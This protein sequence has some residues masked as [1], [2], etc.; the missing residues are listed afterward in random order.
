M[1]SNPFRRR[2]VLQLTPLAALAVLPAVGLLVAGSVPLPAR[3]LLASTAILAAPAAW[4]AYRGVIRH[5][6][7]AARTLGGHADQIT[8][9]AGLVSAANGGSAEGASRQ[10]ASIEEASSSLEEI[11]SMIQRNADHARQANELAEEACA[12]AD[13]GV[14][15]LHAIG[16]AID[17]LNGSSGEIANIIKTIDGIAFQTNLLALNAAVEAARAGSAGA[18]FAIV[19]DEVRK[20][21]GRTTAA[22]Q[23]SAAKIDEVVSWI[24]QCEILKVEVGGSLDNIAAKAR[25]VVELAA[26]VADASRQQA[27]GL[28]QVNTSVVEVSRVTQQSVADTEACA[29]A[30]V[31]LEAH[32]RSLA[33]ALQ[34]L[35]GLGGDGTGPTADPGPAA[36]TGT[37]EA[38]TPPDCLP[39]HRAT[40]PVPVRS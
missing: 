35:L 20:L 9:E 12:A 25:Q 29:A 4:L 2:L 3:I 21:A 27:D 39:R 40:V 6:A 23:E 33:D 37:S 26:Q 7:A 18:G 17:A 8:E 13:R 24:S 1:H 34:S 16:A 30:A 10:A 5:V 14:N 11:S 38:A 32:S 22:S 19:A 15:D 28:G 31:R 36:R